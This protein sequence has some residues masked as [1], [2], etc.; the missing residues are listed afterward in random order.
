[1]GDTSCIRCEGGR[2]C[3]NQL[4]TLSPLAASHILCPG[5]LRVTHRAPNER[6]SASQ[7]SCVCESRV[8]ALGLVHLQEGAAFNAVGICRRDSH[9]IV[10]SA[11]STPCTASSWTNTTGKQHF[12][13]A[14]ARSSFHLRLVLLLL[15]EGISHKN[16]KVA[17]SGV[18]DLVDVYLDLVWV[19]QVGLSSYLTHTCRV[20]ISQVRNVWTTTRKTRNEATREMRP[21]LR[22]HGRLLHTLQRAV[23][24]KILWLRS[25]IICT[26][27]P[28]C[29]HNRSVNAHQCTRTRSR[30]YACGHTCNPSPVR[31]CE[32]R[33]NPQFLSH[34]VSPLAHLHNTCLPAY[35]PHWVWRTRTFLPGNL[36]MLADSSRF[37]S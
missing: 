14:C 12:L 19:V 6:S 32:R 17:Q 33:S 10:D 8:I 7:C 4:L 34:C 36:F 23:T 24:C 2:R 29:M 21:A 16:F 25:W 13:F 35:Q 1:M 30:G 31:D 22:T 18:I 3:R 27:E 37:S 9:D 26:T 20:N 15:G 5:F 11:R 28:S